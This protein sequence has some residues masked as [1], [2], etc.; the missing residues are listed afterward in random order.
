MLTE[1]KVFNMW[2]GQIQYT[3]RDTHVPCKFCG[4]PT[5]LTIIKE[6]IVCHYIVDHI[7]EFIET[8][9]G[10]E[11]IRDILVAQQDVEFLKA[12]KNYAQRVRELWAAFLENDT[13]FE[14]RREYCVDDFTTAYNLTNEEGGILYNLFRCYERNII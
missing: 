2:W 1:N 8:S 13:L 9:N 14:D 12:T 10:Y 3:N 11:F 4:G 7:K 5:R 6:C